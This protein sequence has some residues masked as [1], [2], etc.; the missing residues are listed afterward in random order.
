MIIRERVENGFEAWG[1]LLFRHRWAVVI[2]SL[3]VALTLASGV[4]R[5]ET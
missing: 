2:S 1:H 3:L 4:R 5:L